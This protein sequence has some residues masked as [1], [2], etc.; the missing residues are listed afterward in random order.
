MSFADLKKQS[1]L[2]SLTQKLVKE[3]EKMN[4]TGGGADERLWKPELDKTGNG[5][6]VI[7][8]L[9]SPDG[10]DIPWAKLYSHAF[11]GPGGWYIENSLTTNGGKDP[12]SD[13]NREL[14]NSGNE[15]DKDTVR[16][17]K[18]KLS[19]Y[20][21]I[22]VVKDQVNPQN[23]GK[24]FLF[25]Y[26]K[27]IFDKV[28]EA[29]QPE[30]E[31]ETPINPFDFWQGANFKLKIVKKDGYWNYDKSEFDSPSPLLDDDDALEALWKKEYS[32][33]AVTAPDQF[34]TYDVLEKR[35]KYV[36]G[37]G[38]PA[39]RRLDE[40]LEDESEGRGSFKPDFKSRKAEETV[41]AAV[42]SSSEDEDDALSYF[43][44]LAES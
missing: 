17:Q 19:Y 9:P 8:F 7:R 21:N 1:S 26:G 42:S 25:K 11:Q 33:A 30:F 13:Y 2:G 39:P 10:E 4:N 27:K 29:M 6:A 14:W 34:K 22:Y 43:Q 5:Y 37:Q 36:L 35:L 44:K 18:R 28:M 41:T 40:E 16:K 38:R 23:E 32:L 3:V 31:D 24:V 12:V 15:S 20:S